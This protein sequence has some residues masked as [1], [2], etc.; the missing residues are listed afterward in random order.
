MGLTGSPGTFVSLMNDVFEEYT[1]QFVL[2]FMDDI[3]IYSEIE[4]EHLGHLWVAFLCLDHS[5]Q[6]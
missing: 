6:S 2:C 3:L 5:A 4:D 1:D